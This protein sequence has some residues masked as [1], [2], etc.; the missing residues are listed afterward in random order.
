MA[1]ASDYHAARP[2]FQNINE[3]SC[4]IFAV[5][6]RS[7]TAWHLCADVPVLRGGIVG[8]TLLSRH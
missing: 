1:A 5:D 2:A 8:L 3:R 4:R 7:A 6:A